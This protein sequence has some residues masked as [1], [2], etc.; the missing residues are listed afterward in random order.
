M[1]TLNS[2][3]HASPD[4]SA[5]VFTLTR[6]FNAPRALVFK[7]FAEAERLAKW[8]G[9]TGFEIHVS[10]LEFRP[11]GVFHYKMA[12]PDGNDMWGRFTYREIVEPERIVWIN[13][14]SNPEGDL[15]RAPF[16]MAI[17]LEILNTVT[18]EE[19]GGKTVLHLRAVP[20]NATPEEHEVFDG[21]FE[22]MEMAYGGTFDQLAA[23]LG[24]EPGA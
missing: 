4:P 5:K 24:E 16:G 12:G 22:S 8:W 13:G 21:M 1:S 2:S 3:A 11:G 10:K 15:V 20:I 18:L 19:Q 14:F 23:Y 17:P 6:T 7:A 9:P